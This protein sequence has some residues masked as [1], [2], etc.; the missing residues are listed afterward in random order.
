MRSE[1]IPWS[2]KRKLFL[3]GC[4]TGNGVMNLKFIWGK[5]LIRLMWKRATRYRTSFAFDMTKPLCQVICVVGYIPSNSTYT[6]QHFSLNW[7]GE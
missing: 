6:Y 4:S 1:I 3:S 2:K 7:M 5:C